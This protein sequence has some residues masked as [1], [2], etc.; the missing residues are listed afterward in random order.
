MGGGQHA[1]NRTRRCLSTWYFAL[2]TRQGN[3]KTEEGQ[4]VVSRAS[5]FLLCRVFSKT[6]RR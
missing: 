1:A 5:K 4:F 2:L 6:L 3:R